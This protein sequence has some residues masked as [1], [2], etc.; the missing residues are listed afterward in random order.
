C[1]TRYRSITPVYTN[2]TTSGNFR[3]PSEPHGVYGIQ[4][5]MD[6]I[7]YKLGMDPVAFTLKNMLRPTAEHPFTN[8]SLDACIQMG[9]ETF[10]WQARRKA[11][12]GSDPGPIKRGAGFSFMMFG[13]DHGVGHFRPLSI[14]R[15]RHLLTYHGTATNHEDLCQVF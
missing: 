4:S 3:A 9:V 2:R 14:T 11:T 5:I 15:H 1:R 10:D 12:P 7:A 13:L 8:Y 6:D